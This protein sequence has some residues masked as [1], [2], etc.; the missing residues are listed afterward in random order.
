L[1]IF[2]VFALRYH[3][4]KTCPHRYFQIEKKLGVRSCNHTKIKQPNEKCLITRSDPIDSAL[5]GADNK[6]GA[7][8]PLQDARGHTAVENPAQ[9][10]ASVAGNGD[11]IDIFL[12]GNS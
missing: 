5:L 9:T 1:L 11:H 6:Q 10:A 3:Q 2:S 7:I 8:H 4:A 12:G